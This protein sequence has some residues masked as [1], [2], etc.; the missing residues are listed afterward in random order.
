MRAAFWFLALFAVAVAA[1]V[2]VGDNQ[3]TVTLFWPPYRIDLSLNLALILIL[4]L[5]LLVHVALRT[6]A[7]LFALPGQ[8]QRWRAQQRERNL[9]AHLLDAQLHQYAGRFTRARKSALAALQQER[10]LQAV[11]DGP[12]DA[13]RVRALG[14]LLAAEASHAL[15]D[16]AARQEH[17]QTVLAQPQARVAQEANEGVL[18]RAARWALDDRDVGSA[19]QYLAALPQGAA[20][21]TLALRMRLKAARLGGQA[22]Q[23]LE[24]ARL[25]AKHRAFSPAAAQALVR[26]LALDLLSAAHDADQ[27]RSAWANLEL[28]ER[29]MPEVAVHAAQ[30]LQILDADASQALAWLLPVWEPLT[31]RATDWSDLLRIRWV[32]VLQTGVAAAPASVASQWLARVEAAQLAQ[33]TDPYLQYAAGRVCVS[34]QLWGKGQKLLE[35]AVTRLSDSGLKRQAWRTLETLAQQR[36]DHAGALHAQRQAAQT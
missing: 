36:G 3:G 31:T 11:E 29:H 12:L 9:F 34:Q 28:S 27:L 7:A 4:A 6:L 13:P 20:R 2:F 30:R 26:G 16:R 33:P 22:A 32:L 24:T 19:R 35:Q 23:A 10:A 25:L 17:L 18:M 5:F 15:Q 14:H 8:A 1:A 21:R